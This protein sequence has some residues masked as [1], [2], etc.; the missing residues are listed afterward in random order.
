MLGEMI[1][2]LLEVKEELAEK[3]VIPLVNKFTIYSANWKNN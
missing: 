3:E 2:L 1:L